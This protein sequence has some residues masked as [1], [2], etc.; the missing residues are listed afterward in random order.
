MPENQEPMPDGGGGEREP[1]V[2]IVLA[3]W[4]WHFWIAPQWPRPR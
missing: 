1:S 4:M 3:S 2:W